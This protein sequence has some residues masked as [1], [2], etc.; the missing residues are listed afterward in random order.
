MGMWDEWKDNI[1]KGFRFVA[2]A[3]DSM[4]VMSLLQ[5][6][7]PDQIAD[8]KTRAS[9]ENDELSQFDP[10]F[11]ENF[12]LDSGREDEILDGDD[13]FFDNLGDLI[14]NTAAKFKVNYDD[15]TDNILNII[16]DQFDEQTLGE[17]FGHMDPSMLDPSLLASMGTEAEL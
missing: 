12:Q 15:L 2:L 6:K 14:G 4:D 7:T 13:S 9:T 5:G 8:E 11:M 17:K 1:S 10:L 16:L 3:S